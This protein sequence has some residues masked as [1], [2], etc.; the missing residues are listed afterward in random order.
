MCGRVSVVK[1]EIIFSLR[2]QRYHLIVLALLGLTAACTQ[3]SNE[4][5]VNDDLRFVFVT[6]G[7]ASDPFWSVVQNGAQDAARHVRARVDYQAPESFDM[8]TMGQLID[9]VLASNPDGLVVSIPDASA[10]EGVLS[11]VVEADIPIISINSGGEHSQRLGALLHIGQSEYEAGYQGGVRMAQAGGTRALCINQEVGNLSLDQR[12]AG[13]AEAMIEAGAEADILAVELADPTES[14]QRILAALRA[15]PDVDAL[16]TLGPTGAIP[17][18]HALDEAQR[19]G[20]ILFAT[21]DI[22]PEI[23]T[24]IEAGSVLFAIDQQQYMQGYMPVVLLALYLRNENLLAH[25]SLNTGPGFVTADNVERLRK[26]TQQG[27]R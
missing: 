13:F 19:A 25:T 12:C 21:F 27:T 1:S 5:D 3:Q 20:E 6:H 2:M 9:A 17:T 14:E 8:V 16:M 18:L 11:E 4:A 26:L 24:G 7:Q 23:L 15:D 10:L 22:A